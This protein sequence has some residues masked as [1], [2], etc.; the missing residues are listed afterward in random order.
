[1]P[2]S[3]VLNLTYTTVEIEEDTAWPRGTALL[4]VAVMFRFTLFTENFSR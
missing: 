3:I 1:M 4:A 2:I